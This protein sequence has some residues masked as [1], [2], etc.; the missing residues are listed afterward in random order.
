MWEPPTLDY[1][2]WI[3]EEGEEYIKKRVALLKY[4][5]GDIARSTE[6]MNA[7][8]ESGLLHEY[9][10]WP[11]ENAKSAVDE[12]SEMFFDKLWREVGV[13]LDQ[14]ICLSW[15]SRGG[16]ERI[17]LRDTDCVWYFMKNEDG[18][19]RVECDSRLGTNRK[20]DASTPPS[21]PAQPAVVN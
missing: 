16:I 17:V 9:L 6:L 7:Y 11:G 8:T 4:L 15:S 13:D 20:Q 18:T 5:G 10:A 21:L 1:S 3:G 12:E 19:Y 14:W 2:K